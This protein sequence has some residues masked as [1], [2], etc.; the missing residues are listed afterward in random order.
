M[1]ISINL[2]SKPFVELRPLFARLRLIMAGL[3]VLAIAL[4][5]AVHAL[6]LQ[7]KQ[8]SAEMDALK[9]QTARVQAAT[10]GNAARM[11]RPENQGVLERSRFLNTLFNRKS[12][13]WT[14]VMM[15]LERV[16][17]AGLQVTSI[18]P[19]IA[20][21]GAVSIR[22]RVTGDRHLAIEL[23]RRLEHV[24]RFVAPRITGETALTAE[25]AKA[26]GAA[27]GG[28]RNVGLTDEAVGNGVEFEI[29]S[30]Y[31]A[32]ELEKSLERKEHLRSKSGQV[33]DDEGAAE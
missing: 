7:A 10:A 9:A 23:V 22:L 13:S 29:L 4:G 2:A 20:K 16:T 15:D 30:G 27:T 18:D 25:K 12:F 24:D 32:L 11:R 33:A 14:A 6:S 1:R 28:V 21:D 31:N 17:P 3:A 5:I 8:A 26:I 19:V